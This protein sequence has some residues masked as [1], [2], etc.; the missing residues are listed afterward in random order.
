MNKKTLL[1]A[2]K[3][4]VEKEVDKRV[5][6]IKKEI[7]KELKQSN[8]VTPKKEVKEEVDPFSKATEMLEHTR[9]TEKQTVETPTTSVSNN[10]DVRYSKN[11]VLNEVL[12]QTK[13]FSP[14]E[15][16]A[17]GGASSKSVL[18][19][20]P[21]MNMSNNEEPI[22]ENKIDHNDYEEWPTMETSNVSPMKNFRSEMESKLPQPTSTTPRKEG[23]GVKTGLSGLDRIL[24]RDNSELVKR[25]NKKK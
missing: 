20:L 13:P 5:N 15:R 10:N 22:N 18:D 23:L 25:F 11:P 1:K 4:I 14:D 19:N 6:S 24:N 2:I 16:K 21:N 12:S 8:K 3:V 17:D 7:I 9:S